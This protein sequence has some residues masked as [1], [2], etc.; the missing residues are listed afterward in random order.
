MDQQKEAS[1]PAARYD[2]PEPPHAMSAEAWKRL[3]AEMVQ[4]TE[5]KHK[6]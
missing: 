5:Q 1:P 6:R 4:A 3:K 2:E